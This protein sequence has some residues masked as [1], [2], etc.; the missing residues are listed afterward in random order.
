MFQS[1]IDEKAPR[2]GNILIQNEHAARQEAERSFDRTHVAIGNEK[3]DAFAFEYGLDRREE[4]G[5]VGA[6]NFLQQA[7]PLRA[8]VVMQRRCRQEEPAGEA[9]D[10][11]HF[12]NE[13]HSLY[14]SARH[15]ILHADLVARGMVELLP[16][17][18]P[19]VL[20]WGSGDAES[21]TLVAARCKRLYLFDAAA[22]VRSRLYQRY[23]SDPAIT[24]LDEDS[25][26]ALEPSSL[27][28]IFMVSVVQYLSRDV[29]ARVLDD[30]RETL[31]PGGR[32]VL[33]DIVPRG[34]SPYEDARALLAFA[35]RGGLFFAAMAGLGR[36][37]F[38][39]YRTLRD[40]LG[41]TQWDDAELVDFLAYHGFSAQTAAT[42]IGHNQS[43]RTFVAQRN[44]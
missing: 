30:L 20:D 21:A 33:G 11:R 3:A 7:P 28:C 22:R 1:R 16:P 37:F 10:W 41:L 35:A 6:Q 27:D 44:R 36:T 25:L 24:I 19:V 12:F 4:D 13:N 26:A 43:R 42:N 23:G 34:L 39:N 40:T 29:F 9:M 18:M 32:L 2:L 5:I 38:S 8:E 14:V 15:R 31:A 17:G